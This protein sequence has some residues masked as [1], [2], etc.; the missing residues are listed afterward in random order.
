VKKSS[1]KT[2]KIPGMLWCSEE[3]TE[4][5]SVDLVSVSGA[6]ALAATEKGTVRM[7]LVGGGQVMLE[8]TQV[9]HVNNRGDSDYRD[10]FVQ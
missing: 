3:R 1:Q 10:P 2:E 5:E 4:N 8:H 7:I 9:V 6:F